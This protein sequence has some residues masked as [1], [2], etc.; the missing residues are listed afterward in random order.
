VDETN[1]PDPAGGLARTLFVQRD[2]V[3]YGTEAEA[4]WHLHQATRHS[5]DLTTALDYTLAQER[6]G[7]DLPRIPPLKGR[8][9]LDWRSGP[10]TAGT[11]LVAVARQDRTAPGET[12]T[13]GYA[14]L[15][16]SGGY[17]FEAG[18]MA[19]EVFVRASNLTDEEACVSTSF[20]K[21]IAPLPGRSVTLGVRLTF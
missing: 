19:C 12:P 20:L 7:T 5:L 21:D 8:I 3:F 4:V 10:W 16:L 1:T 2:A 13:D 15:G 17:R 14:L 9:A 11:D 18:R 6:G